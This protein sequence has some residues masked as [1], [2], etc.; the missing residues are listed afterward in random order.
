MAV[1]Q[2][3]S[4]L[5]QCEFCGGQQI[6]NFRLVSQHPV[7][8]HPHGRILWAHPMSALNA[9]LCLGCGHTKLFAADLDQVRAEADRHPER[10]TW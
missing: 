1:P 7:G 10:F 9:I 5:P 4:R 3:P 2:P 6:G 8:I